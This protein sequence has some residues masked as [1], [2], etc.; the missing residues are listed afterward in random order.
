MPAAAVTRMGRAL[1]GIIGRKGLRRLY[2]PGVKDHSSTVG[3]HWELYDWSSRGEA[4][5]PGVGVKSVD[6]RKNISGEGELL[7]M[8]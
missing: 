6:I 5:I 8:N 1:F 2:K 7:A 4:G 3:P